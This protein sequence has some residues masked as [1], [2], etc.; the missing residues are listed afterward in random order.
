MRRGIF[1]AGALAA[2][3][4]PVRAVAQTPPPGPSSP[5]TAPA[6]DV[7]DLVSRIP[8]ITGVVARTMGDGPPAVAV[9][10]DEKFPSAS[11]IKLAIMATVYRA[12]DAGTAKPSDTVRTRASDLIGG[13]DVLA[14]SPA[15]KEWSLDTLVKAMIHVSDNAASNTLITA[16]GMGTVNATMQLAGMT[17]SRLGRHF[18]DVVPAWRRS[19]NVITPADTAALLFAI[20]HGAREGLATIAT[21]QSCRA[22]IGVLL[23]NDDTSKIVRGL[24]PG[25]PCAHKTGEIDFVR[26]DAGIVDPFGDAPYVLVVLTRA[27]RNYSAGNGGIAAIAHRVDAALRG[28]A[29]AG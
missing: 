27:L 22:M 2:C 4:L 25:T 13:S 18:A 29:S 8:G 9:R 7:T 28:S 19:E 21:P 12:Y 1:V 15:G 14:G 6:L 20:E 26:N 3:A 5:G 24:P 16:F 23:G 10:A 11:V 17:N